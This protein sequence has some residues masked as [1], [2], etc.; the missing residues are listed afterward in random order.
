MPVITA[1]ADQSKAASIVRFRSVYRLL[2]RN[3]RCY[4]CCRP[5]EA[6]RLQVGRGVSAELVTTPRGHT[7]FSAKEH[8]AC[9]DG[10]PSTRDDPKGRPRLVRAFLYL[11]IYLSP[12]SHQKYI[13]L[14]IN[15]VTGIV[16]C[17]PRRYPKGSSYGRPRLVRRVSLSFYQS[18]YLSRYTVS[19]QA[20]ASSRRSWI[21]TRSGQRVRRFSARYRRL[22][23]ARRAS[24][25]RKS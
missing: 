23:G 7:W 4:G 22:A 19:T 21:A 2:Q 6:A 25:T 11:S 13:Y 3:A 15:L 5:I 9:A 12:R 1:A 17:S 16:V 20:R 8:R 10:R 24:S 18:I 14:A